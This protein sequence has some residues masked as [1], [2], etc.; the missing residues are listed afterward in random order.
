MQEIHPVALAAWVHAEL[1]RMQPFY[2]G[3]GRIARLLMNVLLV[4]GGYEPV[5]IS[6]K[7]AYNRA[8]TDD[9]TKPGTFA[10]YLADLSKT[11]SQSPHACQG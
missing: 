1:G 2:V 5:V 4:R 10:H 8:L 7:E 11:Q 9:L 3:V 6:D